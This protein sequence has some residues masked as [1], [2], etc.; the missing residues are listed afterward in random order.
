MSLVTEY[1]LIHHIMRD[2]PSQANK[3]FE[4]KVAKAIEEGWQP[5]GGI[6]I[7]HCEGDHVDMMQ[8]MVKRCECDATPQIEKDSK[9]DGK[10]EK[11]KDTDTE[12]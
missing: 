5:L 4:K 11:R 9:T 3:A 1:K 7:S 12:K 8:S 2:N 6:S 10:F